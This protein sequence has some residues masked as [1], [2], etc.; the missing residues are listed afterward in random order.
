MRKRLIKPIPPDPRFQDDKWL[1]LDRLA[2][3]EV[4]SEEQQYPMKCALV[5]GHNQ[6]WRAAEP[7]IQTFA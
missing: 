4:T 2:V 7:G 6:G 5:A 1:N 3:V